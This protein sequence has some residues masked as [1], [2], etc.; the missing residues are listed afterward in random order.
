MPIP[1]TLAKTQSLL[2]GITLL[3]IVDI[4]CLTALI[5]SNQLSEKYDTKNYAQKLASQLYANEQ[6][7]LNS[8]LSKYDK[9]INAI[10]VVY[11]KPRHK[12][13]RVFPEKSLGLTSLS[14]K[15]RN[16][17]IKNKYIDI[18]LSNAQPKI[19]WNICKSNNIPCPHIDKYIL[20]RDEVLNEVSTA[21]NVSRND[22]KNLFIRMAFL[23]TFYNWANELELGDAVYPTKFI[24][25]F[26]NELTT[27]AN[28]VKQHN[29]SLFET[30]RKEK[31]RKK[32]ETNIIGSM[33]SLYLQDYETQI[34][35]CAIHWL[36]NNTKIMD[37]KN[38]PHK[39]ATYEFDGF[40]LLEE[41]VTAYGGVEFII[42]NLQQIIFDKLGFEMTFEVKPIDKY[43][44]IQYEPYV[45]PPT[46]QELKNRLE[47]QDPITNENKN[48]IVIDNDKDCAQHII[49]LLNNKLIYTNNIIFYKNNNIWINDIILIEHMLITFIMEAKIFTMT[50][51]GLRPSYNN[52]S[53][54]KP[55]INTIFAYI[56][57][58]NDSTIYNKFHSTTKGRFAFKDGVLC[59]LTNKFYLWSEINFEYYTTTCINREFHNY[60][61]NPDFKLMEQIKSTIFEPLFGK[62][63]DLALNFI[64]RA[65]M[66]HTEDKNWATY[67]GNRNCG[68]G[69][70]YELMKHACEN[71]VAS[72]K[73]DNILVQREGNH[74]ETAKDFYWLMD[75][76]FVRLAVSQE[77]PNDSDK[78]K[79]SATLI[80]KIASGGDTQI[81]RRNY[82]RRD[83]H[84]ISDA[85]LFALG[86]S[87]LE[88]STSDCNEHRFQF[89]S[90]IQFKK[91][92]QMDELKKLD[93]PQNIIDDH[94]GLID[95]NLK[96]N[97]QSVEWC[98]AFILLIMRYYKNQPLSV[99]QIND[100]EGE[101]PLIF[102]IFQK[103][104]ITKNLKDI[105]LVADIEREF[106]ADKK[107]L[108]IELNAL[109]VLKKKCNVRGELRDKICY[110]GIK[111]KIEAVESDDEL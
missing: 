72:F 87:N 109:G 5:N 77:T 39:I 56:S 98:N 2:D 66:G 44:D 41:N 67:V 18:D 16:T 29:H 8:Y 17:L 81:A 64:S 71:Y 23:G 20:E 31:D 79:I 50:L 107:K 37:A 60:L 73:L 10:K 90:I 35:E 57:Q 6:H 54:V 103:Y 46:K 1:L 51:C 105:I 4:N 7:Q 99:S 68:K 88:C 78:Y 91:P 32:N 11:K 89:K 53:N 24:E 101:T 63:C 74:K 86:N 42:N 12:Y 40:K 92:E 59:A 15:V 94:F 43:F 58:N 52:L 110:F 62:D 33:F 14:K 48:I 22:A 104:E 30:C 3:E 55:V 69:V 100:D 93:L 61:L 108:S 102:K 47:F 65:L 49:K 82:D 96:Q 27:I 9:K 111:E 45:A 97:C 34:M 84:F 21:Y 36:M 75:L 85:T 25:E 83:Y 26:K 13:G 28:I 80:K 19:I 38:S 95:Y 106:G 76:E 70:I